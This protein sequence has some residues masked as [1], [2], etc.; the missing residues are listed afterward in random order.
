MAWP[1]LT[2][3][4]TA[5]RNILGEPTALKWTDAEIKRFINDGVR[6]IAIKTGC[7]ESIVTLTT[8]ASSRYVPFAGYKINSL[9]YQ[10]GSGNRVGLQAITPK[11][12]GHLT[13][14]GVAPQF[15]FQWGDQIVLEPKP[16]ATT[17]TLSAHI[18]IWPDYLQSDTTDEPLIPVEFH[19]LIVP[20]ALAQA[21]LKTRK[22]G[23]A[24]G[25]YQEYIAESQNLI[26][27][28]R[29]RRKDYNS[30]FRAPD[31]V[32]IQQQGGNRYEQQTGLHRVVGNRY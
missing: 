31:T 4:Q 14:N 20:Y 17:Y 21:L 3:I 23:T 32:Q 2:D 22:F 27:L 28:H 10:P 11:M 30:E 7:I 26:D 12:L 9:E 25:Y 16:G 8:V 24:G 18:S 15:Y 13:P 1:D 5:V 6:D 19:P 29:I